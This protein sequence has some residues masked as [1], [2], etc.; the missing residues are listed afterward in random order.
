MRIRPVLTIVALLATSALL[1]A[2]AAQ[3]KPKPASS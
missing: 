1:M 2:P 3:A